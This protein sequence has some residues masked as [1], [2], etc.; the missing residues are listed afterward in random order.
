MKRKHLN[1]LLLVLVAALVIAVVLS[2]EEEAPPPPL[3]NL[4]SEAVTKISIEY[5]EQ[6]A[7]RLE[8]QDS[9]WQ[10][11]EPV[12]V[13][14]DPVEVGAL[15]ALAYRETSLSYPAAEV[16]LERLGLKPP[17][18]S[19][20]LDD[21]TLHFGNKE[22]LQDRR[23]I[24]VGETVFLANDPPSTALDADYSDLV[25]PKL[26]PE[27]TPE[28]TLIE[29]PDVKL[30]QSNDV[31]WQVTPASADHG[32]DARAKL[33]AHW[34]NARSLWRTRFD[35]ATEE[36]IDNDF[37][38]VR[39]GDREVEYLVL[40]RDPQLKLLRTDLDVVYT[41][42]P[43]YGID[44]F[45]IQKPPQDPKVGENSVKAPAENAEQE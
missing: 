28:I 12:R 40:Q 3:T 2:D 17:Q 24:Q 16:D 44:L 13:I 25:H 18:W 39:F 19:I 8:K 43:K 21:T 30:E 29:T 35:P 4:D 20:Q 41:L 5:P 31:Q 6:A 10:I 23:Y 42:A 7:I 36:Q 15:T 32:P 38:R 26:M 27:G 33:L 14:A 37:I 11:V 1:L 9:Q 34:E 22:P 45:E